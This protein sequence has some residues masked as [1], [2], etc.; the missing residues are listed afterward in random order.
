MLIDLEYHIACSASPHRKAEA[1]GMARCCLGSGLSAQHWKECEREEESVVGL[2]LFDSQL[3]SSS[4]IPFNFVTLTYLCMYLL[5][6]F[7][8]IVCVH[9]RVHMCM[10]SG[11]HITWCACRSQRTTVRVYFLSFHHAAPGDPTQAIRLSSKCLYPP[12][13]L[14]RPALLLK[15]ALQ[16]C[17][18]YLCFCLVCLGC[19]I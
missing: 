15:T 5:L 4:K 7:C 12:S 11:M 6:Y 18:M 9:T 2:R 1:G 8:I 17:Y 14:L 13:H 19:L 10:C 16:C 3:Q